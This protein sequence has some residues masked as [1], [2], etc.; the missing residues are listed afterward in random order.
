MGEYLKQA[1]APPP[2]KNPQ[3]FVFKGADTGA[4]VAIVDADDDDCVEY[5]TEEEAYQLWLGQHRCEDSGENGNGTALPAEC[6]EEGDDRSRRVSSPDGALVRPAHGT[7]HAHDREEQNTDAGSAPRGSSGLGTTTSTAAATTAR[8]LKRDP[9][10][11]GDDNVVRVHYDEVLDFLSRTRE[12]SGGGSDSHPASLASP[13]A[14]SWQD[15]FGSQPLVLHGLD[16]AERD[17]DDFIATTR[18]HADTDTN[19]DTNGCAALHEELAAFS[20]AL[21]EAIREHGATT[22]V[23]TGNRETLVAN[24]FHDSKP[25]T[26][27]AA[28][29]AIVFNPV[30]EMPAPFR[31]DAVLGRWLSADVRDSPAA[32]QQRTLVFPNRLWKALLAPRTLHT[33]HSE[34]CSE[35]NTEGDAEHWSPRFTLCIANEGFGIGMHRHGPALFFLT[36]GKKKWYLSHP[37]AI[38]A[39]LAREVGAGPGWRGRSPTHPGFYGELSSHK[40]VQQPGELLLVPNRWYHEIYNLASPTIGVQALADELPV[41][42]TL[43][44][45][46]QCTQTNVS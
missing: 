41:P 46:H 14:P 9:G 44:M 24:G 12:R 19:A 28:G 18:S 39:R 22:I 5:I 34:N 42:G 15:E 13:T 33:N 8:Q 38:D 20:T 3:L 43:R 17:G 37:A 16:H 10:L 32:P 31:S 35:S 11:F 26:L 40:C 45:S 4:S 23:R 6:F 2:D 30:H 27:A 7:N 29:G 1:G 25:A 36:E 21:Q